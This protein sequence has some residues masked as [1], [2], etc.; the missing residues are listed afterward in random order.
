MQKPGLK[1]LLVAKRATHRSVFVFRRKTLMILRS[2]ARLRGSI[3]AEANLLGFLTKRESAKFRS[4][5]RC[6]LTAQIVAAGKCLCGWHANKIGG[7]RRTSVNVF[8]WGSIENYMQ[9]I[10]ATSRSRDNQSQGPEATGRP[11]RVVSAVKVT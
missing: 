5:Q 9:L 7:A 6:E 10:S 3:S 8:M 1:H 4:Q 11:V 2:Y